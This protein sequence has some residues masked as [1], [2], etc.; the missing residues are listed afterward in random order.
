[1]KSYKFKIEYEPD[2]GGWRAFYPPL[3]HLGASTWGRTKEEAL[4]NIREVLSTIVKRLT[5]EGKD[6][7]ANQL[8]PPKSGLSLPVGFVLS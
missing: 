5:E 3:E 7:P 2:E 1:M 8:P 4:E 6:I